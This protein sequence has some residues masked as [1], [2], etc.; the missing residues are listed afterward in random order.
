MMNFANA[1]FEHICSSWMRL[2][3]KVDSLCSWI[4]DSQHD[5]DFFNLIR[6]AIIVQI[7]KILVISV[8]NINS[9]QSLLKHDLDFLSAVKFWSWLTR[10]LNVMFEIMK[11]LSDKKSVDNLLRNVIIK[12]ELL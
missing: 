6:K 8:E 11:I 3:Y 9:E 4:K 5:S 7:S 10:K 1:K 12:S 2:N